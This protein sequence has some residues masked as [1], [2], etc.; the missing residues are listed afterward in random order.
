MSVQKINL[1]FFIVILF[2]GVANGGVRVKEN[3]ISRKLILENK[4][5]S[6]PWFGEDKFKHFFLSGF[7]TVYSYN[8]LREVVNSPKSVALYTS[9]FSITGLG[10]TK[11]IVDLK[12]KKG[13][14][15]F[16]DILANL[17]GVGTA[18]FFVKVL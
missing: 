3:S 9:S 15:S 6:D 11:E 13:H 1:I 18:L 4:T 10:I 2:A 8:F 12:S 7:L 14:P 16:K 5:T 17:L